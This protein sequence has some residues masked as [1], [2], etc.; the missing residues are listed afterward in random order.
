MTPAY[1]VTIWTRKPCLLPT[2]NP[3]EH[4]LGCSNRCCRQVVI[5]LGHSGLLTHPRLGR[6]CHI[7]AGWNGDTRARLFPGFDFRS[8]ANCGSAIRLGR[9]CLREVIRCAT[10]QPTPQ[11]ADQPLRMSGPRRSRQSRGPN[12]FMA[13]TVSRIREG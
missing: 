13:T 12:V 3:P 4:F 5:L 2:R 1:S 8:R 7:G 11:N 6:E 10:I 9:K